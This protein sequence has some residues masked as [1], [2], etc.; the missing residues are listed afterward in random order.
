MGLKIPRYEDTIRVRFPLSAPTNHKRNDTM[1]KRNVIAI[2][3]TAMASI[4]TV[5]LITYGYVKNS[6]DRKK[7]FIDT[8][9]MEG[10]YTSGYLVE[11][12]ARLNQNKRGI[13]GSFLVREALYAYAV[14]G[15]SYYKKLSF[16]HGVELSE[17]PYSLTVY[18]NSKNPADSVCREESM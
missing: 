11:S 18:Y 12:G 17:L 14:D 10:S 6:K 8:A 2:C 5:G 9:E 7:K 13:H 3:A 15:V 1:K 4:G 16:R